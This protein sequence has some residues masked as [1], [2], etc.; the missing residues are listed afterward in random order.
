MK[1][2]L[3]GLFV[4]FVVTL[5]LASA[6]TQEFAKTRVQPVAGS[7][8]VQL[9]GGSPIADSVVGVRP[10]ASEESVVALGV[11]SN[12]ARILS[13]VPLRVSAGRIEVTV[14]SEP[15]IVLITL[16]EGTQLN[17]IQNGQRLS[18]PVRGSSI[19]RNGVIRA[20]HG[21]VNMPQL[22]RE[23]LDPGPDIRAISSTEYRVS[24]KLLKEQAIRLL[25]PKT[26]A[27][28]SAC[29]SGG[30][31]LVTVM[32]TIDEVGRVTEVR[33]HFGDAAHYS[34]CE[35]AIQ[36]WE[37]RPF[38]VAGKAVRVRTVVHFRLQQDGTL[39]LLSN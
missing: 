26:A 18:I 7:V 38:S 23:A 31:G 39:A 17:L 8:E 28:G 29:C 36:Q 9:L 30:Q 33:R 10:S 25:I 1:N 4:T 6:T 35:A 12:G 11:A 15:V 14:Q 2:T 22:L 13:S 37:F 21:S 5:T 32:I 19:L 16:R 27:A 24:S 3:I 34:A 20:A